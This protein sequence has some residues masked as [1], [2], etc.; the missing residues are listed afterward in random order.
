MVFQILRGQNYDFEACSMVRAT[1]FP[2][3]E[4]YWSLLYFSDLGDLSGAKLMI[5]GAQIGILTNFSWSCS[6][7]LLGV[8]VFLFFV[9]V[10]ARKLYFGAL[11]S[12][13]LR[14]LGLWENSSKCCN[15]CQLQTFDFFRQYFC[16]SSLWVRFDDEFLGFA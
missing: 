5:L 8:L 7:L 12:F 2:I 11:F 10:G 1:L 9:I 3:F 14:A 4:E 6:S 13:T 15:G 16:R